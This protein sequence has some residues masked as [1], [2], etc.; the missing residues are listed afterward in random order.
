VKRLPV[1]LALA[2]DRGSE[3]EASPI[4]VTVSCD[5][6]RKRAPRGPGLHASARLPS[7]QRPRRMPD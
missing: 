2:C 4:I 5:R 7:S 1:C 3:G 6:Q